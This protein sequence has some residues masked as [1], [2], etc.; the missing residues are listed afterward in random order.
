MRS[1]A[2]FK[3]KDKIDLVVMDSTFASYRKVVSRLLSSHWL[4]WAFSPLSWLLVS[5]AY[6][7]EE[8]LKNNKIRLLVI[9][10]EED[11]VID[12]SNG[13]DIFALNQSKKEFW[14]LKQGRHVGIF[15]S[16]NQKY[17]KKFVALID[18]LNTVQ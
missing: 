8:A 3:H 9:H 7:T 18:T 17:R 11:P 13:E 10:D 12:I 4:T 14:K 1:L 16:D 15:A 2:D 6:S 5:D